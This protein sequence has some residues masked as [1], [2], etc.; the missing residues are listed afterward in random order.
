MTTVDVRSA[1]GS[2]SSHALRLDQLPARI[3]ELELLRDIGLEPKHMTVPVVVGEI[4]PGAAASGH[5]QVGDRIVSIDGTTV[6]TSRTFARWCRSAALAR[7]C[8][9]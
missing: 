5:L 8:N 2:A 7:R 9:W 4:A 6:S 3:D 1:D